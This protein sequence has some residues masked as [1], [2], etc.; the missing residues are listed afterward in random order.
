MDLSYKAIMSVLD[1]SIKQSI[2]PLLPCNLIYGPILWIYVV[3]KVHTASFQHI[4]MV[5]MQLD[6][7]K[8]QDM[9][10]EDVKL[11]TTKFLQTCLDLG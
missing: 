10:G 4:N 8:F 3:Y 5:K 2:W 1:D 7:P 6:T 9:P 11:F